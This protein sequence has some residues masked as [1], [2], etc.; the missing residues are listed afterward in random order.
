[1]KALPPARPVE[2]AELAR[3]TDGNIRGLPNRFETN[4]AVLR[5]IVQNDRL[6]RP[7]DYV[8]TL[9]ARFRAIDAAALDRAARA[10]LQPD[11]L[12][13]V[14]VGDRKV[15]EPQLKGLA[16]DGQRLPVSFIAAPADGN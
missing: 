15:I 9:P 10:F 1:M 7:D 13:I 16:L 12:T 14:V 4:G 6:G 8:A 5:A 11:G 2:P 3:V